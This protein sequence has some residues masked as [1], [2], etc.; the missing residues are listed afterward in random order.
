VAK[1][2][3]KQ[4]GSVLHLPCDFAEEAQ[5][6][7]L[8]GTVTSQENV[9]G[10]VHAAGV[11]PSQATC[12]EILA[13]NLMGTAILLETMTGVTNTNASLVL[14]ASQASHFAAEWL[15]PA[16]LEILKNPLCQDFGE[17]I[18]KACEGHD[19]SLGTEAY[20]LAKMGVRVLAEEA[21]V[22]LGGQ[23]IR[24][25]T[26]S[27]GIID[28]P[29]VH[30]E[31]KHLEGID[32]MTQITPLGRWGQ[33]EEIAEAAAFLLS[34]AASFVTSADLLVDGGSTKPMLSLQRA[35]VTTS[36]P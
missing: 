28:T 25:N 11:G 35:M 14:I 5:I 33:P 8:V 3:E 24:V 32:A 6:R 34:H 7:E 19:L 30:H 13:I 36:L 21:A 27:P 22:R 10:M 29:M 18:K 20:A 15:S 26:I 31:A 17:R 9:D 4:G 1:Q 2:I 23:G 16:A 12:E